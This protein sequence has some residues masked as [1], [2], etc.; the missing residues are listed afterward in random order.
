MQAEQW[1]WPGRSHSP[2]APA[3]GG[4][5]VDVAREHCTPRVSTTQAAREISEVG[6]DAVAVA[7]EQPGRFYGFAIVGL[8]VRLHSG[9]L[10]ACLSASPEQHERSSLRR[11]PSRESCATTT[12]VSSIYCSDCC[13][14]TIALRRKCFAPG[15]ST[16]RVFER[17]C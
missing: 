15:A 16:R 13:G 8:R 10:A 3:D 6:C 11:R 2:R 17:A 5:D 9:M 14:S 4:W 12:S 1:A 7:V